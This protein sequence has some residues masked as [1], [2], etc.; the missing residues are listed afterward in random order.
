MYFLI[1]LTFLLSSTEIPGPSRKTPV[2]KHGGGNS[3]A[4]TNDILKQKQLRV[5]YQP[6]DEDLY[7][8]AEDFDDSDLPLPPLSPNVYYPSMNGAGS[9][10]PGSSAGGNSG[11][12]H[13]H[14][15]HKPNMVGSEGGGGGGRHHHNTVGNTFEYGIAVGGAGSGGAGGGGGLNGLPGVIGNSNGATRKPIF[16][17]KTDV[18]GGNMDSNDIS[19]SKASSSRS[20][21]MRKM[22]IAPLAAANAWQCHCC[23]W[24]SWLWWPFHCHHWPYLIVLLSVLYS[25]ITATTRTT[26]TTTTIFSSNLL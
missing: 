11:T 1:Q 16:Y 2:N 3:D 23:W 10:G 7:G 26:I 9:N 18:R 15:T 4:D 22:S 17:G 25:L 14:A 8:S 20:F 24:W 13:K 6:D 19:T 12:N 21:F 5:T